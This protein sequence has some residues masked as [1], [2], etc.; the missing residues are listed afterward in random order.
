MPVITPARNDVPVQ[1]GNDVT[2]TG[3]I[4]L[5][6]IEELTQGAF[7]AKNDVHQPSPVVRI[8]IRHLGD[9]A[10]EYYPAETRI[11]GIGHANDA[12]EII[13]PEQISTG[14]TAQLA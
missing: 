8:E 10:L 11:V 14:R 5:V 6:R 9:M 12:T 1:M 3:Q 2:K 13:R 4:D 7:D